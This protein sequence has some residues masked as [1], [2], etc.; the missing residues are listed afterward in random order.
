MVEGL[1]AHDDLLVPGTDLGRHHDCQDRR[2][3][4]VVVPRFDQKSIEQFA[5]SLTALG[6]ETHS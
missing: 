3:S 6:F 1:A 4:E 2:L 5:G